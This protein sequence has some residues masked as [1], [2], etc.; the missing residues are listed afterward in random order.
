MLDWA[1]IALYESEKELFEV[2][3]TVG[4][5]NEDAREPEPELGREGTSPGCVFDSCQPLFRT[6]LQLEQHYVDER[7]LAVEGM[8]SYAVLPLL[9]DE[10]C[11]GV[12]RIASKT[13]QRYSEQDEEFLVEVSKQISLIVANLKAYDEIASLKAKLEIENIYL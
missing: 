11:T 3:V 12:L 5:R 4:E 1:E 8:G 10:K 9:I 7:R 6:D 13:P 2:L